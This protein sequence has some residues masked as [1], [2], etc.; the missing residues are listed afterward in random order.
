MACPNTWQEAHLTMPQPF[1][2]QRSDFLKK[3]NHFFYKLNF[4]KVLKEHGKSTFISIFYLIEMSN[5]LSLTFQGAKQSFN[6]AKEEI[7]QFSNVDSPSYSNS[8][9]SQS[10]VAPQ[11][12]DVAE[13][14]LSGQIS[15]LGD[16]ESGFVSIFVLHHLH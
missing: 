11:T 7:M 8:M 12:M 5:H 3:I 16:T 6:R 4:T 15:E 9:T 13:C 10:Q 1:L 14:P 2:G